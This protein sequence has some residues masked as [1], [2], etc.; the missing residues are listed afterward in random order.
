MANHGR[1]LETAAP[2]E[3]IWRIWSDV[4]TW[5]HWNPDVLSIHLD[6]PFVTATTGEMET[7]AGGKHR[8]VLRDV[9]DGRSFRLETAAVP[10]ARFSFH[11]E[12]APATPGASTIS[13]SITMRG[14]LAPIFSVM[15]GGRIA[16]GFEPILAGLRAAAEGTARNEDAR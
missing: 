16:Q 3:R 15:M 6:G 5:P 12:V 2:P 9:R 14:P 7:R 10:G 4:A 8:I 11:C 13:Q 1:T